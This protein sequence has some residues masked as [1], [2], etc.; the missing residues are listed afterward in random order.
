[1]QAG[2]VFIATLIFMRETNPFVLLE[3]KAKKLRKETGNQNLRSAL[4][5]GVTAKQLFKRSITRP[6]RMLIFSPIILLLSLYVA[7][8]YGILYLLLTTYFRV[9]G[10]QYGFTTGSVGLVFIGFGIGASISLVIS[11]AISDRMLKSLTARNGGNPKPEYRL[12]ML[13]AG[14]FLIPIS[15]FIY[16]W[17]ADKK[18]HWIVPIIATSILGAGQF[19]ILMPVQTYLVDAFTI[20][21]ASATAAATVLR[22]LLGALLPLAGNPMYDALG[23]GWG[24]SLLAFISVAFIPVPFVFWKY[25]ERIRNSRFSQVKF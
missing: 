21:A 22:S 18:V 23:L 8:A 17:T 11:G 4:D 10:G 15:L 13:F 14:A 7:V 16:G 3:R 5:T 19:A 1:L 2:V 20:H 9:F 6:L 25:G 24:T 12:P